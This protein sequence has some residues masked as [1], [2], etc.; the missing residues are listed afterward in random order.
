[1]TATRLAKSATLVLVALLWIT[2]AYFLWQTTVPD[3]LRLLH[4]D[5]HRYW[6]DPALHRAARFDG[7]LRWNYVAATLA[8]LGV[9]VVFVFLA[10]RIARA[11]DVGRV[12]KGVMIGTV[13]TLAAW[14]AALPFG[15]ASLWWGR[16]YGI[17]KETYGSWLV[18]QWPSLVAQVIGLTIVLTVLLLLAGRFR[19]FWWAIAGPLFVVV[20]FVLILVLPYVETIGTRPL[21]HTKLAAQV[22]ELARKEGV[23]STTIRVQTV[24]DQTTAA[25]AM[26]I[27]IGPSAR[28]VF[29]D[30]LNPPRYTPGEIRV[31]A[32]HEFGHVASRHI[33]KGLAW[34]ALLT[35]PLFFVLYL[36]TEWRGGMWRPEVVPFALLVIAVF[37]LAVIPFTNAV[38]RRYEA[39]A[40][41]RALNA[42]RDP[43]HAIGLFRRFG[44]LDL[45]QANPPGWSYLWI[46][47][48]PTLVQRIGMARAWEARNR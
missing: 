47:N 31:V 25:N 48:H 28:V 4:V 39:E 12:G 23:G 22:R 29:W 20:A 17:D 16:R 13:T 21:H 19:R 32:A 46:E 45:E 10:P 42:T 36:A 33:W 6:S 26:T 9:L 18:E 11:F 40:D 43:A 38:S 3:N 5:P 34:Y 27:G 24:S 37:N 1:M 41:W 30:T 14:A 15:F 8:Q 44:R 35:I 7:F 2:A